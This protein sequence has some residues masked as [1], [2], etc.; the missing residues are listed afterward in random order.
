MKKEVLLAITI[1]FGIGLIATFG[2]YSARKTIGSSF[3]IYSPVPESDGKQ[4][5][6]RSQDLTLSLSSPLD[7]SISKDAKNTVTGT[8]LPSAWVVI[9]DEK[10]E[11]VV[12]SNDEGTFETE[13]NLISGENEI[14]V[15]ALS[16]T[17]GIIKK[18]I[19]VVYSTVEI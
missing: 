7:E 19:T 12:K 17:G 4:A 5:P 15:T 14:E 16:E 2:L 18:V 1:G 9:T 3:E 10:E 8:T 6:V 13:I 11:K